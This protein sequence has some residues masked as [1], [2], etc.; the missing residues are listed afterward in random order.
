MSNGNFLAVR[1]AETFS[2]SA[3]TPL[4]EICPAAQADAQAAFGFALAWALTR[5]KGLLV[6]AVPERLECEHGAPYAEGLAQFGADLARLLFV[7]APSQADALW[8]AEQA[9]STPGALALCAIASSPKSLS[10]TATRRLLLLAEKYQSQCILIR[11]DALAPS[12][13]WIRFSVQSAPSKGAAHEL[14]APA[15]DVRL[16]RNRAGPCGQSWRFIWNAQTH[17]FIT[18]HFKKDARAL[19]GD[20]VQPACKRSAEPRRRSAL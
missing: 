7:R 17:A 20:L 15:F 3:R 5:S 1:Q 13:A 6:W 18:A 9:L 4:T 19:D 10:L 14:G 8:A 11:F 16:T 12:A 2:S